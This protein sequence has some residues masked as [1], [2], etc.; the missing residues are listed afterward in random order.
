[1]DNK[2]LMSVSI[3]SWFMR[4]LTIGSILIL[5]LMPDVIG[6]ASSFQQGNPQLRTTSVTWSPDGTRLAFGVGTEVCSDPTLD[7]NNIRIINPANNQVLLSL[8]VGSCPVNSLEWSPDGSKLLGVSITEIYIWNAS[9]GQLLLNNKLG[10]GFL[11]GRWKPDNNVIAVSDPGG[12]IRILSS[13]T[14]Q[15]IQPLPTNVIRGTVMDWSPDGT[16]LVA[17]SYANNSPIIF[18]SSTWQPLLTLNGHQSVIRSVDW[19]PNGTKVA[20]G[21]DDGI[22]KVWDAASGI[23]SLTLNAHTGAVNS[24][25][26]NPDNRLLATTGVDGKL[27]IWDTVTAQEI[28]QVTATGILYDVVWSPN[29]TNLAYGGSSST[30]NFFYLTSSTGRGLRGTYYALNNLTG[31]RFFRLSNQIN[32]N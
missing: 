4:F 9:T 24:V 1:M 17:G 30:V 31:L 6:F 12:G 7:V 19:S 16:K 32:F 3:V 11:F 8:P 27:R 10:Q 22:V 18:N 26:W 21:S 23:A 15:A 25:A 5:G 29:G 2:P 14:G 28:N 20:S 13:I